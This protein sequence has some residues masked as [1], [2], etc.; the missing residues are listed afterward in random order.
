MDLELQINI[1]LSY[2]LGH[3]ISSI[4]LCKPPLRRELCLPVPVK[5]SLQY[6]NV[7]LSGKSVAL[8]PIRAASHFCNGFM[9]A[10]YEAGLQFW[11]AFSYIEKAGCVVCY[12]GVCCRVLHDTQSPRYGHAR[13]THIHLGVLYSVAIRS[14]STEIYKNSLKN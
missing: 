3:Y 4:F 2:P 5:V 14:P 7:S 1:C 9:G 11:G 12:Q 6:E 10:Q 13:N 8:S